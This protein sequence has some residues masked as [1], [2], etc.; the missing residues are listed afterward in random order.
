MRIV[1]DYIYFKIEKGLRVISVDVNFVE[2]FKG[3]LR[4]DNFFFVENIG[5][6]VVVK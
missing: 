5:K 3:F 6:K 1:G 4:F 2:D